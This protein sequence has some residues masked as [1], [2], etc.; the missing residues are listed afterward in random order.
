MLLYKHFLLF[1]FKLRCGQLL[2]VI[3]MCISCFLGNSKVFY[4]VK[5]IHFGLD[6]TGFLFSFFFA[7]IPF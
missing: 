2:V 6:F 5:S 7:K 1:L 3:I 4:Y